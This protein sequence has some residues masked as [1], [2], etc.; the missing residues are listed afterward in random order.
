MST[1]HPSHVMLID[2]DPHLI[3]FLSDRLRRDGYE[4]SSALSGDEAL[5]MLDHRWPDLV[6]LDLM[7]PGLGGRQVARRIKRK[8]DIPV[9]ILSAVT[10]TDSKAELISR[11]AED[12]VTKPFQYLELEARIRRIL[13]RVGGRLPSPDL[14][15]G[16]NLTIMLQRRLAVVAGEIRTLSPTEGRL[17]GV[18]A[19]HVGTTIRTSDLL[20]SVWSG[21]KQPDPAYVWVTVRRLRQ[22]IEVDPNHPIYLVTDP[23]RGYRLARLGDRQVDAT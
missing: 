3:M 16:P 12:Y 2:D 19:R 13:R 4:V 6:I 14:V 21:A 7:M 8:A 23:N 22:K 1:D 5:T 11:Y 9:M 15:L 10:A 20:S 18:L 17:L